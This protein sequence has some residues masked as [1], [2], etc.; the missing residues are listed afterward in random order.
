[1]NRIRQHDKG[2]LQN[3]LFRIC[4]PGRDIP[5]PKRSAR[6]AAGFLYPLILLKIIRDISFDF[7]LRHIQRYGKLTV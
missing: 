1:M 2:L 4:C 3:S 7:I 5:F 6:P